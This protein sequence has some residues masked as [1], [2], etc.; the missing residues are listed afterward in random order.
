MKINR[1]LAA[2][3]LSTAML[4]ASTADACTNFLFTKGATTD[5]STM[6]TYAADSHTLYG[7]LYY[8]RAA[9]YPA[10]TEF[11]LVEWDTGKPLFK[12]PQVAHT[13]SVVGNM[14]EHQLAIGETTYG[15]REECWKSPVKGI[16]YGSLIYVTLQRA[17]T[18]R[19]AIKVMTE[20]ASAYGYCSEGESFSI[21]DPNEVWVMDFIGK[22]QEP[23][24]A[25][26]AKKLKYQYADGAVW[27]AR[28]I[29]DGYVCGHANQARITQFPQEPKKWKKTKGK[30]LHP[31]I[32]SAHIDYIYEPEVECVYA[33]D[34]VTYAR[35]CGWF[36]GQDADFSF[37]DTYAPLTFS[38]LRGCDA[39]VYAMFHR[40][41]SGMDRY[42]KYAMGDPNAERMPLWV[43][44][45]RKISVRDAMNLMRDHYEG[46]AMDMTND[47]GAGPFNCP[48]RWRP[49]GFEVDGQSYIHER[50]TSTQQT[51]FSFV[52]QCRGWLP[53]KI[54]GI[55]WFGVDDTYST[56]YTPMYCGITQIPECFREGNGDMLTYSETSAFWLFNRVTNFVYSRYSD[57]IKDLQVVQNRLED[58]YIADVARFDQRAAKAKDNEIETLLN[59]FSNRQATKMMDEWRNLDRYL[60]VKYIDGNIKKEKNGKFERTANGMAVMPEQRPYRDEWNRMIVRD[61]GNVIREK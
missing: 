2:A 1:I 24:K 36:D 31:A 33:A 54:G 44:P 59:D 49:M 45:D 25:D 30:G 9:D 5:G 56:V 40:V 34:V 35:A 55:L 29:P 3:F 13:Y 20:L 61:H 38:G 42:E 14:N 57:M 37:C 26:V 17:K 6:I 43:K 41:A 52:A 23:V 15:G 28:R 4:L 58:G 46:T 11:M 10:G 18:A 48:Y 16:D 8:R 27:V 51:G 19:E 47:L 53:S 21:A 32:S 7:E 60:L 12:I 39:R 22:R 50:A